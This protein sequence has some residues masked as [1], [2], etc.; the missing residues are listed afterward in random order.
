MS[1]LKF[2]VTINSDESGRLSFWHQEKEDMKPQDKQQLERIKRKVRDL[3]EEENRFIN[4]QVKE[5]A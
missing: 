2:S 4:H 1:K 5:P 3:V